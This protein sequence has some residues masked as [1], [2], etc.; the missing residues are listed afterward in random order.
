[1][2]AYARKL[3]L[4]KPVT[5]LTRDTSLD[6]FIQEVALLKKELSAIGNNFNQVVRK[7]N[8]MEHSAERKIWFPMAISY[9]KKLV[10]KVDSI[11]EN[12]NRFAKSWYQKS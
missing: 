12:I 4:G 5:I 3:L 11:Q 2:S 10:E 8:S 6:D 9:Q 7:I 1:M